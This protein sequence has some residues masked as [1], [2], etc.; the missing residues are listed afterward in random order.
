MRVAV[1]AIAKNEAANV[2]EWAASAA[3][4][5]ELVCLVDASSEDD[6]LERLK[7]HSVRAYRR[8]VRPWRFDDAR[9]LALAYVSDDIDLCVALDLDERLQPGW[10]DALE[11]SFAAGATRPRYRYVWSWN[12]DGTP[13]LVYGGDK[14][15]ARHGYR[16]KHP[17][18]EVLV[19]DGIAE[20]QDW[21]ALEIHHY[22]DPTKSRADY[23]PMLAAAVA[24]SPDDDRL[25]FYY[26]RD[27]LNAGRID[28]ARAEF[29]RH[30]ALPAATWYPERAA[31]MR[32]LAACA[33]APLEAEIWLLRAAAED[34]NRRESWVELARLYHNRANWPACYAAALRALSIQTMPLDY[35]NEA[36]AWGYAPYDFAA[37][38]A[39]EMGLAADAIAYG[40]LAADLAPD[41]ARLAENLRWYKGRRTVDELARLLI[42]RVE[43]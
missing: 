30:L 11:E 13:G 17:V 43:H 2:A 42:G 28:E 18:H 15:H 23:L 20:V 8:R 14:I 29:E 36:D 1:Y 24:E 3:E 4:A 25:A 12:P 39:H 41:D 37:L 10:R 16:W 40:I 31:S 19:E 21:C 26:A 35:L 34:P 32:L 6:T 22:P 27:L 5:D 33:H 9:N 7:A 38:A